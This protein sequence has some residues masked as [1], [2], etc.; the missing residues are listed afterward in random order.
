VPCYK[1]SI[2]PRI[3]L[4]RKQLIKNQISL[5]IY[6]IEIKGDK[7]IYFIRELREVKNPQRIFVSIPKELSDTFKN[8][9]RAS[10]NITKLN[11]DRFLKWSRTQ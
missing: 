7:S 5:G 11:R 6:L 1:G 4:T 9:Q 10:V 2:V 8:R 3:R